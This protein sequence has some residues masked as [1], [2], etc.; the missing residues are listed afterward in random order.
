MIV[1]MQKVLI[2]APKTLQ[3]EL[4]NI[5]FR[6][7]LLHLVDLQSD[8]YPSGFKKVELA[9]ATRELKEQFENLTLRLSGLLSVLG[10]RKHGVHIDKH[11]HELH[12]AELLKALVAIVEPAE[13]E[14]APVSQ[15]I[16]VLKQSE[17]L[18][19]TYDH[20]LKQFKGLL[21]A[22]AIPQGYAVRGL[23]LESH[24]ADMEEI[25]L[26]WMTE[27]VGDFEFRKLLLDDKSVALVLAYPAAAESKLHDHLAN[28]K[29]SEMRLPETYAKLPFLQALTE[30]EA[31]LQSIPQE[32]KTAEVELNKLGHAFVS[33]LAGARK[34]TIA[35][36]TQMAAMEKWIESDYTFVTI[37]WV[38]AAKFGKFEH[39]IEK[40]FQG[41][42]FVART[43]IEHGDEPPIQ[44]SNNSFSKPFEFVTDMFSLPQ[45]GLIDPTGLVSVFF[46][47]FFG[48]IVGDVGYALLILG[49]AL[50]IKSKLKNAVGHMASRILL[51]GGISS[52]L[53]GVLF[54]EFFGDLP[55]RFHWIPLPAGEEFWHFFGFPWPFDRMKMMMP[56]LLICIGVG[57]FHVV[58]GFVLGIVNQYQLIKH[59]HGV[60]H[61]VEKVG[62]LLA[63]A[64]IGL[65]AAAA[66]HFLPAWGMLVAI[67]LAVL[68]VGALIWSAGIMGV[69]EIVSVISNIFSYSRL[70]AVGLAGAVLAYVANQLAGALGSPVVGIIVALL[71]HTLNF[72]VILFSP[73]IHS[74]RLNVV[75]FFGKFHEGGGIPYSPFGYLKEE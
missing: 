41:Q 30:M 51:Y 73:T 9:P 52:L 58:F 4:L 8:N 63:L 74:I 60:K 11:L 36:T 46:T 19:A 16:E 20:F 69:L 67:G 64:A 12:G 3:S 40:R 39:D 37:G 66:L 21:T 55:T 65:S 13:L 72:V 2:A 62:M 31:R 75:E 14:I 42:V 70:M 5:L 24:H 27:H 35:A 32:L 10:T 54:G 25:L 68:G 7:Q 48:L 53:F 71:L 45:Y 56:L 1:P 26:A 59:G 34:L 44:L 22:W 17:A 6:E 57:A 33:K 50:L 15:R 29:L 28:Q 43:E 49:L 18:L 38:P 23:I 61:L 47:L